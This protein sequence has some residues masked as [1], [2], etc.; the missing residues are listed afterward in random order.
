MQKKEFVGHVIMHNGQMLVEKRKPA[1]IL[2]V[3]AAANRILFL[4]KEYRGQ[5]AY[6]AGLRN[7]IV[8][9]T[10]VVVGT[11]LPVDVCAEMCG[12][13]HQPL[14]PL[15]SSPSV[16]VHDDYVVPSDFF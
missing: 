3:S 4:N 10:N 12:V 16:R 5:S 15:F 7:P 13:F 1:S 14:P 9:V 2:V 11:V 6:S 8:F